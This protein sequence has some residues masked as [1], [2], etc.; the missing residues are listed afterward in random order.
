MKMSDDWIDVEDENEN[1]ESDFEGSI[2]KPEMVDEA[3]IGRYVEMEENVGT[4]NDSTLYHIRKED[5]ELFKVWGS[6]LLDGKFDKIPL[7]SLVKIVYLGKKQSK[8]GFMYKVFK[9]QYKAGGGDSQSS[10]SS[11][12]R[13]S[14]EQAVDDILNQTKEPE[15]L[16]LSGKQTQT[17]DWFDKLQHYLPEKPEDLENPEKRY[18][19][20]INRIRN[21]II[22][23]GTKPEKVTIKVI[24][25]NVAILVEDG[26]TSDHDLGKLDIEAG[27]GIFTLLHKVEK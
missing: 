23:T 19:E 13:Q 17:G 25:D 16:D 11:K 24:R 14:D 26:A 12:N 6:K 9:V 10:S 5:G 20:W 3:L 4:K 27:K 18:A 15:T 22:G 21:D 1:M 2:W 7:K 8:N